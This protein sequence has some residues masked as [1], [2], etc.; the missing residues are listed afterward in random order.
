MHV[1]YAR[2][3]LKGDVVIFQPLPVRIGCREILFDLLVRNNA[4]LLGVDQEHLS[5][6]EPS[7]AQDTTR[8]DLKYSGFGGHD[9]QIVIGDVVA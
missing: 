5:R 9:N 4:P 1:G 8:F 3:I 6:L 7:L 2:Q